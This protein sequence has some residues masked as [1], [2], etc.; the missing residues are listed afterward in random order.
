[1]GLF[2]LE[3]TVFFGGLKGKVTTLQGPLKKTPTYIYIYIVKVTGAFWKTT[4][5]LKGLPVAGLEKTRHSD[6]P[7]QRYGSEHF[8]GSRFS[9][10][11]DQKVRIQR[12]SP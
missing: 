1:M 5:L 11:S 3:G 9:D 4:I 7:G 6:Q 8:R 10:Q 2:C 12:E